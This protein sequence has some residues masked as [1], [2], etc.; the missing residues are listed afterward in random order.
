MNVT[1]LPLARRRASR[2]RS[3]AAG[4]PAA[5]CSRPGRGCRAARPRRPPGAGV[6]HVHRGREL[7]VLRHGRRAELQAP[8]VERRVAEAVAEHVQRVA[9]LRGRGSGSPTSSS[10]RTAGRSAR[11]CSRSAP[12]RRARGNDTGS[13][14]PGL[15]LPKTTSA[16]ALPASTPGN[17]ASRIAVAFVATFDERQRA[18]VE[19]HDGERLPG[20]HDRVEQL[21]LLAGQVDL[22]PRRGL[23]AHLARLAHREHD[24]IGRRGRR[25][26]PGRSR[27]SSAH[28]LRV[29]VV[30]RLLVAERAALR[31]RRRAGALVR[32]ALQDADGVVVVAAAPPRAEHVVLAVGER[33]DH[34][35]VALSLERHRVAVV[36]EQHHRLAGRG[37]RRLAVVGL[38]AARRPP[39]HVD[40][41]VIEQPRAELDAQDPPHGVVEPAIGMLLLPTISA[42]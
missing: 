34:R 11:G 7:A 14:P 29:V 31:E 39:G 12:G 36:L 41:R 15:T 5:R 17:Q 21:L 4:G 2:A 6:R 8:D 26:P 37:A 18:P 32:D 30:R 20:R 3:R 10:R 23:A 19:Q 1:V 9:R 24:L 42:P 27:T 33:A 35:G 40:V 13:L 25:R 16:T 22:G 28:S 38:R